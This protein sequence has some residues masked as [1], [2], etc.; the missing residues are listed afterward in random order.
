MEKYELAKQ[1]WLKG[2]KYKDIAEKYEVSI[3]TVKSWKQRKWD[4]A[5]NAKK[6][7]HKKGKVAHKKTAKNIIEKLTVNEHLNEEQK[8][9]CFYYL[10]NFNATKSYQMAYPDCSYNTA[11]NN[12]PRLLANA[13][14]KKEVHDLMVEL[15]TESYLEEEKILQEYEKQVFADYTDFV[16]FDGTRTLL[17]SSEE[18]DGTM[19]KSIEVTE[20]GVKA[21]LHDKQKAMSELLRFRQK[22]NEMRLELL[23]E[24]V[25]LAK[26]KALI[27]EVEAGDYAD[28]GDDQEVFESPIIKALQGQVE[29]EDDGIET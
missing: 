18:V 7:A 28:N 23:Q 10:Q 14:I 21:V 17:K 8:N 4:D 13:C 24:Q 6:G 1:D 26:A 16:E 12:G 22:E 2:M 27:A 9:F 11:R 19:I 29:M 15:R 20:F 5:T 3:N 25:K